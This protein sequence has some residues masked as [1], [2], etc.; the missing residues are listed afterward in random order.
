MNSK[1][2]SQWLRTVESMAATICLI[3]IVIGM[4]ACS[5]TSQ[6]IASDIT[7]PKT[8][9]HTASLDSRLAPH[10]H[11][12]VSILQSNGFDVGQTADPRALELRLELDRNPS[13]LE[14]DASLLQEGTALISARGAT[15]GVAIA[16]S[17]HISVLAQRAAGNFERQL[18]ALRPNILIVADSL[19]SD[20]T[21]RN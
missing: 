6:N 16:G 9:R 20:I 12:F 7:V 13:V 5:S 11:L 3:F 8:V 2:H 1:Q 15:D 14:L 17:A 19:P 18:V 10:Y 4:S 21:G